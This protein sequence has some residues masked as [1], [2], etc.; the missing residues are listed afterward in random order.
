MK[1]QQLLTPNINIE[2][3]LNHIITNCVKYMI[4]T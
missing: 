3:I 2:R 1:Q 4:L